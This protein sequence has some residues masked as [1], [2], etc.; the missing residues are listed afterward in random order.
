MEALLIEMRHEQDVKLKRITTL[1][2]QVDALTEH[3][4]AFCPP[5][6]RTPRRK[7]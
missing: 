5:A 3:V 4:K 7:S 6:R 2:V 1:Q